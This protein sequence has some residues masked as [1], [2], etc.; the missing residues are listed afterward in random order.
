MFI[1]EEPNFQPK[2]LKQSTKHESQEVRMPSQISPKNQKIIKE[3][4]AN[5]K[6]SNEMNEPLIKSSVSA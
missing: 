2:S 3:Q 5:L 4:P 6:C 1:L